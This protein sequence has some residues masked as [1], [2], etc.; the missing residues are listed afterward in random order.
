VEAGSNTV[1][2]TS[3]ALSVDIDGNARPAGPRADIGAD[4]RAA[5]QPLAV[6]P[7]GVVDATQGSGTNNTRRRR[8]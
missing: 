2:S 6:V 7:A 5:A 1:L 3:T 8:R 4:E